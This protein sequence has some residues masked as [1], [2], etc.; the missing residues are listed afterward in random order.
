M[1]IFT[2]QI[3]G[4]LIAAFL[5]KN[6][7]KLISEKNEKQYDFDSYMDNN[8]I[9]L[10]RFNSLDIYIKKHE[11]L[12]NDHRYELL[13]LQISEIITLLK[14]DIFWD[15]N[16]AYL[17]HYILSSARSLLSDYNLDNELTDD[18]MLDYEFEEIMNKKQKNKEE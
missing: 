16:P 6:V 4:L 8:S 18:I 11:S 15:K 5:I 1:L 17:H 10:D 12:K 13:S 3:F 14:K 7:L 2:F 9:L